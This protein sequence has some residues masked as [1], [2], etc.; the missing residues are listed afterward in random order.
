MVPH[1]MAASTGNRPV[2]GM[3]SEWAPGTI[4]HIVG[5]RCPEAEANL[6]DG[7]TWKMPVSA[8]PGGFPFLDLHLE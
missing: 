6:S 2:L 4:R 3:V 5:K 1:A 7:A 8:V